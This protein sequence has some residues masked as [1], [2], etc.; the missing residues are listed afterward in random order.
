MLNVYE[1]YVNRTLDRPREALMLFG[2]VFALSFLLIPLIGFIG[3]LT[4]WVL[5]SACQEAA[6]W[7]D[8]VQVSVN[9]SPLNLSQ[10]SLV[11]TVTRILTDTGLAPRRLVLELTEGSVLENSAVAC[12]ALRGLKDLGV[13]LWIDDFGVGHANIAYL[14][15][16][17]CDVVKIDRSFLEQHDKRREL[18]TGMISLAQQCGLRVVVEGI[19]TPEQEQLLQELGCDLLQGFLM[20][21]PMPAEQLRA[22]LWPRQLEVL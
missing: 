1:R 6:T 14:Q 7:V 3:A 8:P 16:L 19:E 17:P 21:R 13:E 22:S 2:V 20:G 18:L 11:A 4:E 10:P 5:F 12:K 15:Q 9:L